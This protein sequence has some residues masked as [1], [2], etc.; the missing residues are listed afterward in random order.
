MPFFLW[1][2]GTNRDTGGV[3]ISPAEWEQDHAQKFAW[4]RLGR[5]LV[6]GYPMTPFTRIAFVGDVTSSL[7]H[8]GTGGLRYI[9]ADYTL[10]LSRLPEGEF[11][12]LAAQSHYGTDGVGTGTATLFDHR[13]PLGSQHGADPG[14][15]RRRL[16]PAPPRHRRRT[17]SVLISATELAEQLSDSALRILDVRWTVAQP[18]GRA[19]YQDG[20]I[21][22]AVYVD[23]DTDLSDHSVTRSGPAPVAV[24]WRHYRPA[25]A[26]GDSNAGDPVVVYDDWS[27]Q[28][29][30]RAWWLLRAAGVDDV[31]LL[32]GGWAAWQRLGAPTE[33]VARPTR[34]GNHCHRRPGGRARS[35]TPTPSPSRPAHPRPSSSTPAPRPAT[36]ATRN[37]WIRQAGHIPGAVS[38][39]TAENLNADGTFRSAAELRDQVSAAGRR[40]PARS[41]CTA[42]LVSPPPIRSRRWPSPVMTRRC[43]PGRGR[44]G[45]AHRIARRDRPRTG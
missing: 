23:L 11:I 39:P 10:A 37:R 40:H 22:G 29:A 41:R 14:P 17:V 33:T 42:G 36:A 43:I 9:N 12:G 24:S 5:E 4:V 32:D 44:S 16:Q 18:D 26:A 1:T 13:G 25:P 19:A 38:A 30:A 28:A 2:Y 7:T 45:P 8:W 21:P 6:A 15:S 20:H 27:G 3:G 34:S 31:R 35:S